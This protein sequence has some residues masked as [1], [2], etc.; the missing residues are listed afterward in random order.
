MLFTVH[1]PSSGTTTILPSIHEY[2]VEIYRMFD[3]LHILVRGQ[4]VYFGPGAGAIDYFSE[5]GHPVPTYSNPAD[6]FM[7]VGWDLI[8]RA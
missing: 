1:Q 8:A 7:Q 6:H 5:L 3:K 2:L 4:T